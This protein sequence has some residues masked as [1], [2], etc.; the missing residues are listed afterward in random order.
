MKNLKA[1]C[2]NT[3]EV[4]L[5]E[6][7]NEEEII[8][9]IALAK[10]LDIKVTVSQSAK[11]LIFKCDTLDEVFEVLSEFGLIE[12]IGSLRE[13]I[14]WTI[15]PGDSSNPAKIIKFKPKER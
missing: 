12:Y 13:I 5:T 14:E 3:K 15:V 6:P 4:I 10:A 7:L 9:I 1:Q 2:T 8:E 11:I